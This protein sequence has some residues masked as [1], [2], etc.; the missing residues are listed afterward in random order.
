[1]ESG[2]TRFTSRAVGGIGDDF[3]SIIYSI[4]CGQSGGEANAACSW[5]SQA[6]Y[7]FTRLGIYS[8]H[9]QYVLVTSINYH[10]RS[11]GF[12]TNIP[13]GYLFLCPTRNLQVSDDSPR[14]RPITFD[15][16][17]WSLDSSGVERLSLNQAQELDFPFIDFDMEI[18]GNSWDETIYAQLQKLH[19]SKGFDPD[20]QDVAKELKFPLYQIFQGL[21]IPVVPEA[22]HEFAGSDSSIQ[23]E[24]DADSDEPVAP[25]RDGP[26]I[27]TPSWT[28]NILICFQLGLIV[29]LVIFSFIDYLHTHM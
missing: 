11:S 15:D 21:E 14:F 17:Y 9:D 8:K 16:F 13:A 25:T 28:W 22:F 12:Q 19:E 6:N 24:I 26:E 5:L 7:I 4:A 23:E 3:S 29:T 2:W 20:S 27:L 10:L 18:W 1:M